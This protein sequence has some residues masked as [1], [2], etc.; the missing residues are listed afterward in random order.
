MAQWVKD[1]VLSLLWL[2][3]QLLHM[4]DPWPGSFCMLRVSQNNL[5]CLSFNLSFSCILSLDRTFS[6]MLNNTD[7]RASFLFLCLRGTEFIDSI[8]FFMLVW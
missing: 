7:E 1:L 8:V 4:F 3:L 6:M 5:S 2:G